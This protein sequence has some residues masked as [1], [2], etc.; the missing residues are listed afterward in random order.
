MT[1]E[2]ARLLFAGK[3]APT[4]PPP[5]ASVSSWASVL[6]SASAVRRIRDGLAGLTMAVG[7]YL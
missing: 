4:D 3:S 6:V 7:R 5:W 1:G 2:G